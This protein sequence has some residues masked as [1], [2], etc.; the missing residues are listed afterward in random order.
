MKPLTV[1][2]F[3]DEHGGLK[4]QLTAMRAGEILNNVKKPQ[5][6]TKEMVHRTPESS[7]EYS[8]TDYVDEVTI[9]KDGGLYSKLRF[10]REPIR[11]YADV[12]TIWIT[13]FYKRLFHIFIRNFSKANLLKKASMIL[14]LPYYAEMMPEWFEHIFS[15]SNALLKDE[16]YSQPVKEIRRVLKGKY[17]QNL[18]DAFTLVLE[19]DSAYR[20]RF[21]DLV[22]GYN[23]NNGIVK[24]VMI[25]VDKIIERENPPHSK[26]KWAKFRTPIRLLTFIFRKRIKQFFDELNL[27]E[28][29]LSK[30]DTY[31]LCLYNIYNC[32]GWD[33]DKKQEYLK[34]TYK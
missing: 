21:Q 25:M 8:E 28:I 9:G 19:Y 16:H 6:H 22:V 4:A 32:N 17:D 5:L 14:G 10:K 33:W 31:F 26:E 2:K 7:E 1:V 29:K 20:Y 15:M 27:D 30:E 34:E 24:E 13:A 18:V 11:G 12:D 23:R 3:I